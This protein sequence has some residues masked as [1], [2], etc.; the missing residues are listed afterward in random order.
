MY[1][2]TL[3]YSFFKTLVG[4]EVIVELKNDMC[5]TG[6]LHSVDQFL[7]I[8]LTD[9]CVHDSEKYP[10]MSYVSESFIRGSVVRYVQLPVNYV[11]TPLLQ[12]AARKET[13][14]R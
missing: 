4:Y 12:D 2:S 8:K 11:D 9:I 6:K 13:T 14:I 5:V 3:F 10:Y 1:L 7:N